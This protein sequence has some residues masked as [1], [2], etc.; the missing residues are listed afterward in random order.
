PGVALRGSEEGDASCRAEDVSRLGRGHPPSDEDR[1][2]RSPIRRKGRA[3]FFFFTG[4]RSRH[5]RL[6]LPRTYRIPCDRIGAAQH[7]SSNPYFV[8]SRDISLYF[9]GLTSSKRRVPSSLRQMK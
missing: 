8:A 9:F 6:S 3:Y 1:L 5:T 7:G 2:P 4:V